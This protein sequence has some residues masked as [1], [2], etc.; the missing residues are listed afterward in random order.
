[1]DLGPPQAVARPLGEIER[2]DGQI[3]VRRGGLGGHDV[4][5]LEAD[6]L[7]HV[8]EQAEQLAQR[9]ARR[10]DRLARRDRAVRLDIEDELVEVRHLPDLGAVDA[11]GDLADRREDRVDGD[12]ADSTGA[13]LVAICCSISNTGGDGHLHLETTR[14]AESGDV[15]IGVDYLDVRRKLEI[16]SRHITGSLCREIKRLLVDALHPDHNPLDVED[17]VHDVFDDAGDGGELVLDTFDLDRGDGGA[18]YAAQQGPAHRVTEC[19]AEA[20]LERL[21]HEPRAV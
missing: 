19:V 14:G 9:L 21:Y 6:A 3:E 2:F 7:V 1:M 13:T 10:R 17:D 8:G 4:A 15:G 5:Q 16:R 11:V 18:G 12:D 20:R